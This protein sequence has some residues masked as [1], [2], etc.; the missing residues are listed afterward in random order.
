MSSLERLGSNGWT[1][2][3]YSAF[4]WLFGGYL[5]V[6]LAMLV[7]Y[8]GELFSSAG[9]LPDAR[10]SPLYGAFP[11]PLQWFDSPGAI[12]AALC[13][14]LA[15]ATAFAAGWRDRQ[16]AVALWFVL[17]CL[18]DRNPL[19]ANPS[20]PY[21]GWLLLAHALL[22][23]APRGAWDARRRT[24][25]GAAWRKPAAVHAAA[26]IVM[27]VGYGYS[28]YTKLASPSWL[29]G[30]AVSHVLA[31]PLARPTALRGWLLGLPDIWLQLATWSALGLELGFVLLALSARAR[32][33]AWLAMLSLHVGLI[34]LIDFADLTM[35][36]LIL[37]A[38]TFDPAWL[39]RL[40][41]SGRTRRWTV[42]V[43]QWAAAVQWTFG[44]LPVVPPA[45][46]RH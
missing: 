23:V 17:T 36:M 14:G 39:P 11:N 13:A 42:D 10:L 16:A 3:Q 40:G 37:H 6:H 46:I 43:G 45:P 1:G 44:G 20:L 15:L 34:V 12:T 31:N 7:P 27:A 32:P 38:F 18:F 29:D 28:G 30:S 26:W 41:T 4:R 8:G 24:D 33:F 2:A 19:I 22:P 9:M 25:G 5:F 35:G 21:V